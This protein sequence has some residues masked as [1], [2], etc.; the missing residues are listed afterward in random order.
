MFVASGR[1]GIASLA[2]RAWRH[3][4]CRNGLP[5][6]HGSRWIA[7]I[8]RP[9]ESRPPTRPCG[10]S[11]RRD[12]PAL[13]SSCRSPQH[14]AR[15][16]KRSKPEFLASTPKPSAG[17]VDD[18][19]TIFRQQCHPSLFPRRED[20]QVSCRQ[21]GRPRHDA[22]VA[23]VRGVGHRTLLVAS[24]SFPELRAPSQEYAVNLYTFG[25]SV[26]GASARLGS[27]GESTWC[28]MAY[29][30]VDMAVWGWSR[31]LP[32]VAGT[33][34]PLSSR[35]CNAISRDR[36]A[37]GGLENPS[38]SITSTPQDR[39]DEAARLAMF[40]H[41]AKKGDQDAINSCGALLCITGSSIEE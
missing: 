18:G 1:R 16:I 14:A 10:R 11:A 34:A 8:S 19:E 5:A 37:A 35:T 17:D 24:P 27:A 9:L 29:G 39:M 32:F 21:G 12:G 13:R 33:R 6:D 4:L 30:I 23:D 36:R 26:T 7:D 31:L 41:L 2:D 20:R 3:K 25:R 22:V 15:A 40:P 38:R 28:A